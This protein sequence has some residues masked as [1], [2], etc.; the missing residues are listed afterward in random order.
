MKS[1]KTLI[2]AHRGAS[3]YAPENTME[4]F[5]FA[6]KMK[7]D[8]IELD[9]QLTKDGQAVVV[10]D[11]TIDRVS[12]GKG[13]VKDYTLRE[14]RELDFGVSMSKFKNLK[15]PLLTD[16]FEEFKNTD[17]QFNI[18]LKNNI[19]EYMLLEDIVNKYL[20]DFNLIE[21]TI[22]SSFN[23]KSMIKLKHINQNIKIAFLYTDRLYQP[24]RYLDGYG[25][26]F[27]H[28]V[29][30]ICTEDELK[31]HQ[32]MGQVVNIW[33]VNSGSEIRRFCDMGV[34]GIITNKPDLAIEIKHDYRK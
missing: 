23:H 31:Q 19:V 33:T 20:I 7:A 9:V 15:I 25:I 26:K 27:A 11:E 5:K 6:Y 2:Y 24:Y 28:P 4:A 17:F 34:D 16:V 8:G 12:N 30:Y 22:C 1:Y 10:H 32:F 13:Y 14:L 3:E 18:E 29:H 21:K